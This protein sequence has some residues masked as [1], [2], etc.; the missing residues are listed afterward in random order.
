ML[1]KKE[2]LTG[3]ETFLPHHLRGQAYSDF[4]NYTNS[5]GRDSYFVSDFQP[6][7]ELI[8][9]FAI[10][11]IISKND[12][13]EHA[14][15]SR[16]DHADALTSEI[17]V[18]KITPWA[19]DLRRKLFGKPGPPFDWDGAMS[20]I[21]D[22]V[23]RGEPVPKDLVRQV[24]KT[25]KDLARFHIKIIVRIE[26]LPYAKKGSE[27]KVNVPARTDRLAALESETRR[28]A[29]AT[30]FSQTALVMFVLAG[31][32]PLVSRVSASFTE[33]SSSLPTDQALYGKQISLTFRAS[34]FTARE[35][36][37]LYARIKQELKLKRTVPKKEK[38]LR[39]Y[40]LVQELG[41][42]PKGHGY[43]KYWEEAL[44]RWQQK[45]KKEPPRTVQGLR[46][47]WER[48]LKKLF[49]S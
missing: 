2:F 42:P 36:Q 35:L 49:E 22:E 43:W 8:E 9:R 40:Q 24:E 29:K 1:T 33:S 37:R 26:L 14:L 3:L 48:N 45:Y 47:I 16:L 32:K 7:V 15:M 31:I 13:K 38:H 34:D 4:C 11:S 17:L 27:W 5:F 28:I 39:V 25:S 12:A 21:E 10:H 6:A 41:P 30:G 44:K 18:E 19:E 20:W 23:K 46:G